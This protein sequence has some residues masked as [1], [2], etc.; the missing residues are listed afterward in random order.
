MAG[1]RRGDAKY[2]GVALWHGNMTPGTA[3]EKPGSA[4]L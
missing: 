4:L 2:G 3:T 1:E